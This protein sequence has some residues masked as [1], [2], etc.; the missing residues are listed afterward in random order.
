MPEVH[1]QRFMG[2]LACVSG[3]ARGGVDPPLGPGWRG[4]A[5]GV[6]AGG[7]SSCLGAAAPSTQQC[8]VPVWRVARL[9]AVKSAGLGTALAPD[10]QRTAGKGRGR[11]LGLQPLVVSSWLCFIRDSCYLNKIPKTLGSLF[12]LFSPFPPSPLSRSSF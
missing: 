11:D 7:G 1:G 3:R 6:A 4:R 9:G 5:G 10:G 2:R 12:I 8:A